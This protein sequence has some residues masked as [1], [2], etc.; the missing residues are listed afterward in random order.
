M[1]FLTFFFIKKHVGIVF[2]FRVACCC[3][4]VLR[5]QCYTQWLRMVM[6][7]SF[8][9]ESLRSALEGGQS[10]FCSNSERRRS[11]YVQRLKSFRDNLEGRACPHVSQDTLLS[12]AVCLLVRLVRW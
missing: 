10:I 12:H 6:L 4:C 2:C 1:H 3:G 11:Q 5:L 8:P 7:L 9:T